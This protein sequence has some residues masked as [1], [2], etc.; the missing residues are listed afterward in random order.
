M[1][2]SLIRDDREPAQSFSNRYDCP[3]PLMCG[4]LIW[5]KTRSYVGFHPASP[6][7]R[8]VCSGWAAQSSS[9]RTSSRDDQDA[10]VSAIIHVVKKPAMRDREI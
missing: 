9:S 5:K 3:A 10:C 1:D 4:C 7:K 2:L 6:S 8:V